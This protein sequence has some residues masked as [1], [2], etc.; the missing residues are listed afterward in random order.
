MI[1]WRAILH[2][3]VGTKKFQR[4]RIPVRAALT[5]LIH[6]EG[7]GVVLNFSTTGEP[8]CGTNGAI[9]R[10]RLGLSCQLATSWALR[11]LQSWAQ[12][13]YAVGTSR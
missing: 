7:D 11:R 1:C 12:A 3:T 9:T 2:K 6:P 10:G 4:V 8:E 5:S 13:H